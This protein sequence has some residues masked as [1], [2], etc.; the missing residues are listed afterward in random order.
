M[1][2]LT[3][4]IEQSTQKRRH[5][6]KYL[7]AAHRKYVFW[8]GPPEVDNDAF[9]CGASEINTDN[10]IE[11][12][13][14]DEHCGRSKQHSTHCWRSKQHSTVG[15]ANNTAPWEEQITQH[16]GRSKQHSTVGG[17]NNTAP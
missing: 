14:L 1:K 15:G 11:F 17:A 6:E 12:I 8:R 3:P 10:V 2:L 5:I 13:Q 9:R 16:R 4:S 7:G